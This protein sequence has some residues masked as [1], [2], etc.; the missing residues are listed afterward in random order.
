MTETTHFPVPSQFTGDWETTAPGG[1][2]YIIFQA[3]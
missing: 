1:A 3:T 2:G